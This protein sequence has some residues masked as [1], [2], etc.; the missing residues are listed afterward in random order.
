MYG[1]LLESIQHFI[2]LEYGEEMWFKVVE[3]AGCKHSVFNTHQVYPDSVMEKLALSCAKVTSATSDN[4]M[5]FFGRCFVRYFSNLGY[6]ITIRSTGRY[7]TDFLQSV[8][9][10]HSQFCFTYPKMKSPSIYVTDIDNDGCV[11]VYRSG[12]QGFTHYVMGNY[13]K[14]VMERISSAN[15]SRNMIV[16]KYRLDFD[17]SEYMLDKFRKEEH[18]ETTQLSTFPAYILLELFPFAILIN[19]EMKIMAAGEKITEVWNGKQNILGLSVSKYFRLRRPKGV[20]FTFQNTLYL[21]KVMYEIEFIRNPQVLEEEEFKNSFDEQ[22]ES[23]TT[24]NVGSRNILLKGQMKYIEDIDAIVF[25]CSPIINDL[26]ELP[27]QGLYLNDL[28]NHGLSKEMVLAGWQ[29]N[30]KLEMMFDAAEN[31]AD[32]LSKSYEL[33]DAWKRKGDDLLYSMIPKT[34]ADRLRKGESPLSTCESFN[35]VTILFGE[36]VGFNYSTVEDAMGVVSHMNAIFSGFDELMD[37]FHVYKV[38][39]VGQVYM[40]VSGAPEVDKNHA[41]NVANVSI[42]MLKKIKEILGNSSNVDVRIGIH[43]GSA[44]AGVVGLKVPRYCFFGDSVNTAS[45]MQSTSLP[46]KINISK[47]TKELLSNEKYSTEKRGMVKV[48]GKG[49]M[50]TFWLLE[51]IK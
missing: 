13:R 46:G 44:V 22:K 2:Q 5:N 37:K 11:L 42:A 27:E 7:F 34:V 48:K 41:I 25:L 50:E 20:P 19:K 30:S 12:R 3:M 16:V 32:E 51:I 43:S 31:K 28:N 40:A 18:L 45:R 17:N 33:L 10:I 29:H 35:S 23:E 49:E 47:T 39:T 14:L 21:R 38:E 6:D 36:L 15:G 24:K 4:F 26:D 1:M 9:N 8:D